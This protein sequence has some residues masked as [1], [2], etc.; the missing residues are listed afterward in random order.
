V[1][2]GSA[3]IKESPSA[4]ASLS[5]SAAKVANSEWRIAVN[6]NGGSLSSGTDTN[7]NSIFSEFGMSLSCLPVVNTNGGVMFGS[8]MD[9]CQDTT[10]LLFAVRPFKMPTINISAITPASLPPSTPYTFSVYIN[11]VFS[12]DLIGDSISFSFDVSGMSQLPTVTQIIQNGNLI[13]WQVS[14][15]SPAAAG[16]YTLSTT[17]SATAS[18]MDGEVLHSDRFSTDGVVPI[19]V[20]PAADTTGPV[21]LKIWMGLTWSGS[22]SYWMGTKVPIGFSALDVQSGVAKG[23]FTVTCNLAG[24]TNV[25]NFTVN[26]TPV[27]N[28]DQSGWV[29]GTSSSW[30]LLL[31]LVGFPSGVFSLAAGAKGSI[32]IA[33]T[34]TDA[35]GNSTSGSITNELWMPT[36]VRW[37]FGAAGATPVINTWFMSSSK[38]S[39][40]VGTVLFGAT[41]TI[42]TAGYGLYEPV[43]NM[44]LM[45]ALDGVALARSS[46]FSW[47]LPP[48][49]PGAHTLVLGM[50]PQGHSLDDN[51]K[52]GFM[53][54]Q[55][56][57]TEPAVGCGYDGSCGYDRC[58]SNG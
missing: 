51:T 6:Y 19:K 21:N 36:L 14:G 12:S 53:L 39:M 56:T 16:S 8:E 38:L 25:S 22:V 9:T 49:D 45:L 52:A 28:T 44:E 34:V 54:H 41:L 7:G 42:E 15:T 27:P 2:T 18:Y 1:L 47:V 35:A 33:G 31:D 10:P 4:A 30:P 3:Y 5:A 13:G 46:N 48:I 17:L 43:A 50:V 26:L 20:S 37:N 40:A 29:G 32:T 11:P 55:L 57:W 24:K 58:A 23:Y